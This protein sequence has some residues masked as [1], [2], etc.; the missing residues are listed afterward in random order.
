VSFDLLI[1]SGNAFADYLSNIVS[2]VVMCGVV[3]S[4]FSLSL[5]ITRHEC[6]G[7]SFLPVCWIKYHGGRIISGSNVPMSVFFYIPWSAF[8]LLSVASLARACVYLS[9]FSTQ[10]PAKAITTS[11]RASALRDAR[12]VIFAHAS[13]YGLMLVF[14]AP[15]V[16]AM[17]LDED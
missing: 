12:R 5:Y 17:S 14:Y 16:N 8:F 15:L 13:C 6:A 10:S 1:N 7:P 4:M 11:S 9:A 2:Y 3:S